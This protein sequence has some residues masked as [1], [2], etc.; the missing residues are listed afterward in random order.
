LQLIISNSLLIEATWMH[1]LI[2]KRS[3]EAGM[4]TCIST[5]NDQIDIFVMGAEAGHIEKSRNGEEQDVKQN[6]RRRL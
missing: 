4:S 1:G 2:M 6:E 3:P 5:S